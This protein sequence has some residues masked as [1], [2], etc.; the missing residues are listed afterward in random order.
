MDKYRRVRKVDTIRNTKNRGRLGTWN[1]KGTMVSGIEIK[2]RDERKVF[3]NEKCSS[4]CHCFDDGTTSNV[5]CGN[6]QI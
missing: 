1:E 6:H 3:H 2:E 5:G 4:Y